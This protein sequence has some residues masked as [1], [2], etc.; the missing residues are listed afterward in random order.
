MV[1]DHLFERTT[2]EERIVAK[3]ERERLTFDPPTI[4]LDRRV[5]PWSVLSPSLVF[6]GSLDFTPPR[7]IPRP[8]SHPL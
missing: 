6:D 3:V 1:S 5:C 8:P 7:R 2:L 4:V